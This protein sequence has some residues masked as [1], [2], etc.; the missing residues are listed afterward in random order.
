MVYS[1]AVLLDEQKAAFDNAKSKFY[2]INYSEVSSSLTFAQN[3]LDQA[4]AAF[5][6]GDIA[7][8]AEL[9]NG[10]TPCLKS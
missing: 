5:K 1:T 3:T 6:S 2:S 10:V 9:A 7:K 8:A 4:D